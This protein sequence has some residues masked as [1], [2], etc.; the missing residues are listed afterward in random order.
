M[1][2]NK[3]EANEERENLQCV[4]QIFNHLAMKRREAVLE[5]ILNQY[6]ICY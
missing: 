6:E 4:Y 5:A 3:K 2:E 1:W